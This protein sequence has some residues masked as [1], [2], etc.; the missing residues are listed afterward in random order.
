MRRPE[1]EVV[2]SQ[3][4]ML[5]HQN[6]DPKSERAHLEQ[7]QARHVEQILERLKGSDRV[8]ILEVDYPG[9]VRSPE[10]WAGQ[11]VAFL[12]E[13]SVSNPEAMAAVVKPE[14]Y[15]NRESR[16]A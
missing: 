11:L 9:L 6:Q 13:A 15:R 4:K 8:D 5:E 16:D 12:G 7:T 1:A 10:D 2:A 3:W 14:L